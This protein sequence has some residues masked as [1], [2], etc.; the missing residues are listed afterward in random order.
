MC[1]SRPTPSMRW[2]SS[3][4]WRMR[5]ILSSVGASSSFTRPQYSARCFMLQSVRGRDID[6]SQVQLGTVDL[7]LNGRVGEGLKDGLLLVDA[8]PRRE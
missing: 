3:N 5:R 4:A 8:L 6:R 2:T 1:L 7:V